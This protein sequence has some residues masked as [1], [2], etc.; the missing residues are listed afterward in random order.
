MTIQP[1]SFDPAWRKMGFVVTKAPSFMKLFKWETKF[2]APKKGKPMREGC[3]ATV[4]TDGMQQCWEIQVM[5][6]LQQ[7]GSLRGGNQ[8]TTA[9]GKCYRDKDSFERVQKSLLMKGKWE[10]VVMKLWGRAD[11]CNWLVLPWKQIMSS[12]ASWCLQECTSEG[13]TFTTTYCTAPKALRHW[14]HEEDEG[15]SQG[16]LLSDA[17]T[18]H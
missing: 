2:V 10:E 9:Q 13:G 15:C 12:A 14:G 17:H 3:E 5:Q 16:K 6:V 7:E 1:F 11:N 8:A 18:Q 4:V